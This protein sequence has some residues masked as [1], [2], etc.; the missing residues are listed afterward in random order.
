MAEEKKETKKST[1]TARKTNAAK[2]TNTEKKVE[3]SKKKTT[4]TKK[5]PVNKNTKE[6]MKKQEAKNNQKE[7]KKKLLNEKQTEEQ[8]EKTLFFDG[9][10]NQNLAEVVSRLEEENVVLDD[11]IVK[12]DKNKKTAI[13]IIGILMVLIILST[14]IYVVNYQNSTQ[15]EP[16][17]TKNNIYGKVSSKYK[18]ENDIPDTKVES[19]VEESIEEIKYS[20]IETITLS[21][22]E[23]KILK[24]EDMIVLVASTTCYHSITFEPIINEVFKEKDAKIY[25]INI[26]A[27]ND[28]E[29]KRF[30]EYY[31]FRSTPT[32][33]TIENGYITSDIVG[34]MTKEEFKNW[35]ND[36][37][38]QL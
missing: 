38:K 27:F 2:K 13:I 37:Y 8:L 11:K 7:T 20:N 10:Q 25:R 4:T 17:I 6:S 36:N 15:E 29:E 5:T 9:R 30:R 14:T 12:R 19:D 35:V 21:E 28:K 22:F 34:S 16:E 26:I 31:A 23:K 18:D 32:I 1:N 33:F 3:A 24:K